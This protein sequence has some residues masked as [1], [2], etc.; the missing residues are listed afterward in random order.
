MTRLVLNGSTVRGR[1][2]LL[3]AAAIGYSL[4][5][6]PQIKGECAGRGIAYSE[7]YGSDVMPLE[8]ADYCAHISIY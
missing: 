8:Y 7:Y 1:G 6:L 2:I 4:T 5:W 3:T